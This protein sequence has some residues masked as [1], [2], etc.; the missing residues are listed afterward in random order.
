M[1]KIEAVTVALLAISAATAANAATTGG[2]ATASSSFSL[3]TTDC[4]GLKEAVTIQL[5]AANFGAVSCPSASTAGV[6]VA[7]MKGKGK[8][9]GASS[10]GGAITEN[11]DTSIVDATTAAAAA[12]T[13]AGAAAGSS[14]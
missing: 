2:S 6:G 10:N 7:N 14:G 3:T 12:A 4:E 13:A 11:T 1:N 8:R 9:Y 5:S